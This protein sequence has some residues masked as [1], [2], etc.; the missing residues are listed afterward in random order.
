M[1]LR[2]TP[3]RPRVGLWVL[4][5]VLGACSTSPPPSAAPAPPAPTQTHDSATKPSATKPAVEVASEVSKAPLFDTLKTVSFERVHELSATSLALGTAPWVAILAEAPWVYDGKGWREIALPSHLQARAGERDELRI[6][7]GRDDKPRIMG[8]RLME[9]SAAKPVYLR[10][11]PTGWKRERGE[12]G[13]L[14]GDTP[15]GL[16]GVLGHADPEVVCKEDQLC[17]IKRRTGWT[18]VDTLKSRARVELSGAGAW[19]LEPDALWELAAKQWQREAAPVPWKQTPHSVA[20]LGLGKLWVSAD[21]E[22]FYF[23]GNA[24]SRQAS[25][26]G[27]PAGL[28][29]ATEGKLAGVWLVGKDGVAHHDGKEWRRAAGPRGPLREVLG[30]GE[31]VWLAGGAGVWRGAAK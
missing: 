25:P 26:V 15:G 29:L 5:A 2:A 24:W 30:R 3:A 21:A 1:N 12:I 7:F 28:W 6:F 27:E 10:W 23:D 22:L 9:G 19:A 4:G 20:A 16:F 31:E 14:G 8:S 18:T 13:R 11:R 17:I